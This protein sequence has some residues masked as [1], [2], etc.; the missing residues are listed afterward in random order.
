[1]KTMGAETKA[2]IDAFV[3]N[4]EA[5]GKDKAV[6]A[7]VKKMKKDVAGKYTETKT[8]IETLVKEATEMCEADPAGAK[9]K[10]DEFTA[11]FA[12]LKAMTAKK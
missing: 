1:M 7:S 3:K 8:A 11:K 4:W 5:Y 12:D 10:V 2:A 6:A 9:V